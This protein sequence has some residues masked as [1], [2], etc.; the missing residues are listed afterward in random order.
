MTYGQPA[1]AYP[2]QPPQMPMAQPGRGRFVVAPYALHPRKLFVVGIVLAVASLV[3]VVFSTLSW[4]VVEEDLRSTDVTVSQSFS[5]LGG[6]SVDVSGDSDG[7][8]SASDIRKSERNS[9]KKTD[10]PGAWTLT[11]GVLLGVS[12]VTLLIRRYQGFGAVA[13]AL[14]GLAT[15]ITA[16]VFFADPGEAVASRWI[17]AADYTDD[18]SRGYGIWLVF[19]AG[20]VVLLAGVAALA[21]A[22][23]PEKF[24]PEQ[25][26]ANVGYGQPQYPTAGMYAQPQSQGWQVQPQQQGWQPVAQPQHPQSQYPQQR[27]ASGQYDQTQ[28]GQRPPQ[29]W[30]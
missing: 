18:M 29:G 5:G 12:A 15:F 2:Y 9:E 3:L 27:P 30:Q 6:V 16:T 11:F 10:A 26:R 13:A 22:L 1:G 20:L 23:F 24:R 17:D 8:I 14:L 4:A 28:L 19:F 7:S 21:L 25:P